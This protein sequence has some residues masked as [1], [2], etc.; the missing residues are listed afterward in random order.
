M[1]AT[2]QST[3]RQSLTFLGAM[4]GVAA[5]GP[6]TLARAQAKPPSSAIA[7]YVYVGTYTIGIP[8]GGTHTTRAVGIY[9]FKMDPFK[10]GLTFIQA[11]AADSPSFLAIDPQHKYLYSVN[12]LG[13]DASGTMA[14]GRVSAYAIN[15]SS[16]MLT[17][18]NTADTQGIFPAHLSVHPAGGYLFV[19]NYGG[20]SSAHVKFPGS[21]P[22]FKLN[23]NGSIGTMTQLFPEEG[24]GT[25]PDPVRQEVGHAHMI[26]ADPSAKHIFGVDLGMDEV[27]A[28]DFDRVLGKLTPGPIHFAAVGAG[29]GCR[30]M[31]FHPEGK[32]AYVINELSSTVNAH[33]F[34]PERGAF[35]WVQTVSTL[36]KNTKFTRPVGVSIPPGT[37][38]CS[39]I[40]IH[41]SGN[42]LYGANRGDNSIAVFDVDQTTGKLDPK[43]WVDTEGK[44][45]RGFDIDPSG[46]FMYVGNQDSDTIAVFGINRGNGRLEGPLDLIPSPTPVDFEFGPP[47]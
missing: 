13:T 35:I 33:T 4:A 34:D 26:L 45:P 23:G 46:T 47:A 22:V 40:R 41:P 14:L 16:G 5:L 19:A 28:W 43:G 36:P 44:I 8:P 9:V 42:F 21:F 37:N 18:L 10:G 6:T 30:H 7:R 25:G 31:V 32:F 1:A 11:V 3:R 24:N 38:T 20:I 2:I 39:E 29:S 27:K 17:F 15:P 12:E